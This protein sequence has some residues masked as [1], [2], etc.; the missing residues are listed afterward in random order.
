MIIY[1]IFFIQQ[2][3]FTIQN[4]HLTKHVAP[5]NTIVFCC[6][7]QGII[8]IYFFIARFFRKEKKNGKSNRLNSKTIRFDQKKW[9]N[10]LVLHYLISK[11]IFFLITFRRHQ[12]LQI[13]NSPKSLIL[14]T[15]KFLGNDGRIQ[16]WLKRLVFCRKV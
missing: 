6:L 14:R 10:N 5:E 12:D 13:L 7:L 4:R 8:I 15:K 9:N 16:K 11:W 1:G 2:R 3:F